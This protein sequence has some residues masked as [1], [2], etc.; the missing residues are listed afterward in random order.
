MCV[1]CASHQVS[2]FMSTRLHPHSQGH[3]DLVTKPECSADIKGNP[4]PNSHV[5]SLKIIASTLLS[6]PQYNEVCLWT[7]LY[8]K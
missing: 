2:R 3:T 1:N 5:E 6:T 7:Y 8:R 4:R